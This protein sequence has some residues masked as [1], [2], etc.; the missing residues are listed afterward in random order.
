MMFGT[1]LIKFRIDRGL[2]LRDLAKRSG[3]SAVRI[4]ELSLH[5]TRRPPSTDEV[6]A[7]IK[8]LFCLETEEIV[9]FIKFA[10]LYKPDEER[11]ARN[12]EIMDALRSGKTS[13]EM[14]MEHGVF[15]CK[16]KEH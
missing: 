14:L 2:T 7:L 1:L 16:A 3:L 12:K 10:Q 9:N 4:S 15:V 5:S 11:I 8:N 6:E 13:Q